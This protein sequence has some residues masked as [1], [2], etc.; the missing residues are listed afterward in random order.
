MICCDY[1]HDEDI[2]TILIYPDK[3]VRNV[4][5]MVLYLYQ[6]SRPTLPEKNMFTFPTLLPTHLIA[7]RK[8][9]VTFLVATS[10]VSV[11]DGKPHYIP[12]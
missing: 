5:F 2:G 3:V 1:D 7:M 10:D 11:V 4:R 8:Q 6:I 12:P 9:L